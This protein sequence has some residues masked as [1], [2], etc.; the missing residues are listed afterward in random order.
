MSRREA[1]GAIKAARR[2]LEA[3]EQRNDVLKIVALT[4]EIKLLEFIR[5]TK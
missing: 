4:E 1:N 5:M 3:A 2:E